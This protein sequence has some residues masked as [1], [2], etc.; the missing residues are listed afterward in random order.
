MASQIPEERK[1]AKGNR[2]RGRY[3]QLNAEFQKISGRNNKAFF[4]EYH[5]ETEENSR[6]GKTW[7][8]FE[9]IGDIKETFHAWMIMLKDRNDKDLIEAEEIKKRWQENTEKL[10]KKCL[11]D[12]NN[13]VGLVTHL[14]SDIL[15]YEF[16]KSLGTI[17]TNKASGGDR[18]PSELFQ[19]L[20]DDA[21]NSICQQIWKTQKC[22]QDGKSVFIPTPKK[23]N[24]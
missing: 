11:N 1:K 14:E 21:V 8:I 22:S 18:F 2:E 5:K 23:G 17:T 12:W 3:T 4:K 13:H 24:V 7:D 6:K 19:M 10:Y 16:K 9:K 15:V 20:K